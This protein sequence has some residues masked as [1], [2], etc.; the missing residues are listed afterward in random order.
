M[1]EKVLCGQHTPVSKVCTHTLGE[2]VWACVEDGCD[3]SLKYVLYA[4]GD[5]TQAG[6][7]GEGGEGW[8]SVKGG[9]GELGECVCVGMKTGVRAVAQLPGI[10]FMFIFIELLLNMHFAV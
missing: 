10:Y 2:E 1:F 8:V 6:A 9:C 5:V 7:W 4:A 3:V